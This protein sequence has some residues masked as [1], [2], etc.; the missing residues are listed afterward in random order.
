MK[1]LLTITLCLLLGAGTIWLYGQV[2][3]RSASKALADQLDKGSKPV[4]PVTFEANELQCLPIPVQRYFRT[5]LRQGQPMICGAV[6]D[7][8]GT[9]N[10]SETAENWKPFTSTQK[11]ITRRPGFLWDA[12]MSMAPGVNIHVRDAFIRGKGILRAALLGLLPVADIKDSRDIAQGELLR[13]FAEA[14]WYPTALLPS[15]GVHWEAIDARSARATLTS[16]QLTATL[17]FRFNDE[18]LID[19]VRAEARGRS[20]N[21]AIVQTPWE[22]RWSNYELHNGMRIPA[23]GTVAWLLPE[24]PKPYWRGSI[25]SIAY[26]FSG[27]G[28]PASPLDAGDPHNPIRTG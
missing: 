5:V 2:R 22:G 7:H 28:Q 24:G 10:L 3:W 18:G 23:L 25:T 21:G 12:C 8:R 1:T 14:A 4:R 20:V 17:L 13:F 27:S 6:I 9:F 19:S 11:I 26:E 15:Q 16:G